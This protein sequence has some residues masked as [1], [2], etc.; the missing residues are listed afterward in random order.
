MPQARTQA[1][2]LIAREL[3]KRG[4]GRQNIRMVEPAMPIVWGGERCGLATGGDAV[5]VAC[6]Q[7]EGLR[8]LDACAAQQA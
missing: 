4:N 3:E 7:A 2:K 8:D 6:I 1:N 5:C